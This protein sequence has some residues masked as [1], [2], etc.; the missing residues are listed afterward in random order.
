MIYNLI[1]VIDYYM[2]E[3][4]IFHNLLRDL[5]PNALITGAHN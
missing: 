5:D 4:L 2:G 3:I 1:A